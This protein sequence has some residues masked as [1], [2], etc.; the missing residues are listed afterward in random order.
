M[1]AGRE[2]DLFVI[3]HPPNLRK[4]LKRPHCRNQ[5]GHDVPENF[6]TVDSSYAI[7]FDNCLLVSNK[8]LIFATGSNITD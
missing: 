8:V 7:T 3:I 6:L 4:E 5:R 2:H 1:P